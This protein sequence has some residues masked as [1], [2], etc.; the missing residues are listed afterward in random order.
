M[1]QAHISFET[2]EQQTMGK[3]DRRVATL[4]REVAG[5]FNALYEHFM[6]F[7]I[8]AAARDEQVDAGVEAP[9]TPMNS[10]M[11]AAI[12]TLDRLGRP[13]GIRN[14]RLFRQTMRDILQKSFGAEV[15]ELHLRGEQFDCLIIDGQHI[16]VEIAASVGQDILR[17]LE[18]KRQLYIDETGVTPARF[19]LAV[20]SIHSRRAEALRAA[21]FDVIEPEEE[22]ATVNGFG[23]RI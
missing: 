18:R 22:E 7:E 11:Y 15:R 21:G 8:G 5:R 17:R 14:E 16:L 20:G 9:A 2:I 6:W 19:I 1:S 4:E 23:A 13:W 12:R 10:A 3:L